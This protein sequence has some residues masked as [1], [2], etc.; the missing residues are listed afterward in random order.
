MSIFGMQVLVKTRRMQPKTDGDDRLEEE[1]NSVKPN[2]LE[3]GP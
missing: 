3:R 2:S 1:P